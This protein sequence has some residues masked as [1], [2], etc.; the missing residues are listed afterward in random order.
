[1][2]FEGSLKW[3][4]WLYWQLFERRWRDVPHWSI[5]IWQQNTI[6]I[7][8]N[9]RSGDEDEWP[10]RVLSQ[11]PYQACMRTLEAPE[12]IDVRQGWNRFWHTP[13]L[14]FVL[15]RCCCNGKM[16]CWNCECW[17]TRTWSI[18]DCGCCSANQS[19]RILYLLCNFHLHG[20]HLSTDL[21][22]QTETHFLFGHHKCHQWDH[23][24]VLYAVHQTL[25]TILDHLK[26]R[27]LHNANASESK[28]QWHVLIPW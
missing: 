3:M 25:S 9:D 24:K 11:A 19:T 21:V 28:G 16:P 14:A 8:W 12:T 5:A 22:H 27:S 26:T 23:Q 1:M 7:L 18:V 6:Q 17:Q 2:R 20:C 15:W 4:K 13:E 10:H